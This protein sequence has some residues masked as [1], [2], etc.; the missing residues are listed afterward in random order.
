MSKKNKISIPVGI[1]YGT[2]GLLMCLSI[3]ILG[4]SLGFVPEMENSLLKLTSMKDAIGY[5][6]IVFG[7]G[8]FST[9]FGK[10]LQKM[11]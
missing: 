10:V 8:G 11:R 6:M 9:G 3:I 4:Q 1:L 5:S 7:A 2:G